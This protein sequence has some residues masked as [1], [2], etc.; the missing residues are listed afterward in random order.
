M[1]AYRRVAP[2]ESRPAG[3]EP[4]VPGREGIEPVVVIVG[5][6]R[7]STPREVGARMTVTADRIRGSIGGGHLEYES[8]RLAR[9]LPSGAAGHARFVLGAALGQCCGG[10]VELAFIPAAW[11]EADG[12][13]PSGPIVLPFEPASDHAG[14]RQSGVSARARPGL[15]VPSADPSAA[16]RPV[17][18]SNADL[19]AAGHSPS[20]TWISGEPPSIRLHPPL[21]GPRVLL[22]GAGHVGQALV[23]LLAPLRCEVQWVDGRDHQEALPTD[24]AMA[25]WRDVDPLVAVDEAA[26]DTTVLVMT[27]DHGLD[28]RIVERALRRRDLPFVGLIGSATKRRRFEQRLQA[29]GVDPARIAGLACPIGAQP[30]RDKSPQAIAIQVAA[31][32]LA[33]WDAVSQPQAPAGLSDGAPLGRSAVVPAPPAVARTA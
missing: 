23:G 27:H 2:S 16:P 7:G 13:G 21:P 8:I 3:G 29:A 19:P 14:W 1:S 20:V 17:D 6:T 5:R 31:Q 28:Y 15:D 24:A 4:L 9:R 18:P 33:H 32:L 10:E 12:A 22:C 11:L 25:G 26:P 30:V